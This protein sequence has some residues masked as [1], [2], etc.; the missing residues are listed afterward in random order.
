MVRQEQAMRSFGCLLWVE[1]SLSVGRD[2]NIDPTSCAT[3]WRTLRADAGIRR[4]VAAWN[5]HTLMTQVKPG[6]RGRPRTASI[7]I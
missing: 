7:H 5:N 4:L 2:A 3:A 6:R 1:R